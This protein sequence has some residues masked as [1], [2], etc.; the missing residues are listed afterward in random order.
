M[1]LNVPKDSEEA[2]ALVGSLRQ[3]ADNRVCFD[4]PQKNPSWCSVTYGIFLCMDCCGRHRGMGVHISF[5]RSA[6]LDSW[7]PEEALRMALGG[8]AAARDFFKQHGCNDPKMRYNAPAAQLYRKR[9][10][11][12]MVECLGGK[13]AEPLAEEVKS[14]VVGLLTESRK[15]PELTTAG[16][17]VMQAPVISMTPKPGKKLGTTKKKGFGG[18]QKVEGSI[19]ETSDPVPHSLLHDETTPTGVVDAEAKAFITDASR[20]ANPADRFRGLGNPA[21]QKEAPPADMR[22]GPDFAG[23]GSQ[24][25]QPQA[26]R[27]EGGGLQDTL[28]QVSEAWDSLKE[29]AIRSREEWG[30]KV[31]DFLDDL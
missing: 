20:P 4:C 3:N 22:S 27:A 14:V 28:W 30:N 12:R 8:N 26:D 16:S 13:V 1:A 29:S 9:L 24:P 21:F 7:R 2:K 5:M 23:L 19:K 15:D 6:D 17:P 10:D 11:R 18:A 31:R 25:Y